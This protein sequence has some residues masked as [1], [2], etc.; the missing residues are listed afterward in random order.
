MSWT[1]DPKTRKSLDGLD[2]V[3]D[4]ASALYLTSD[5]IIEKIIS[6]DRQT[7]MGLAGGIVLLHLGSERKDD[8]F[9]PKLGQLIDKLREKGYEVGSVGSLLAKGG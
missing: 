6:F 2:W 8:P 4:Q 5:E 9:H 7:E 1:Y 3:S